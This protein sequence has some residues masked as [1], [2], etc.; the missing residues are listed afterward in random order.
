M[1]IV[2]QTLLSGCTS[3]CIISGLFY[4]GLG[5]L[6]MGYGCGIISYAIWQKLK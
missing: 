6:L 3:F 4:S 2:A 1:K 5:L